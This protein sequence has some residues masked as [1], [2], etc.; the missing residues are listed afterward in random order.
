MT[1]E[2][3]KT[4]EYYRLKLISYK[5]NEISLLSE[6]RNILNCNLTLGKKFLDIHNPIILHTKTESLANEIKQKMEN[7]GINIEVTK[8]NLEKEPDDLYSQQ[9]A[10]YPNNVNL[11][12]VN[13]IAYLVLALL[14][15]GIGI[16]KFY[17]GYR[18]AGVVYLLFCWTGIPPI[19][20]L[21][22]FIIGC[23]KPADINGT[24]LV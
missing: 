12:S 3:T 19:L 11:Q 7:I 24:I 5:G 16:H 13:K 17:A 8:V 15:G 23:C 22:D 9:P 18:I 4:N 21:I 20:S 10:Y 14:L 6:V 1:Y 2:P